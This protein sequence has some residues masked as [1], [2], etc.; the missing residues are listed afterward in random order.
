MAN[1]T[2]CIEDV[3]IDIRDIDELS[4]EDD[5]A[6]KRTKDIHTSEY[7]T[8]RYN[9]KVGN[10]PERILNSDFFQGKNINTSGPRKVDK[11]HKK[12]NAAA[13]SY[14]IDPSTYKPTFKISKLGNSNGMTTAPND[15]IA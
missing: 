2:N 1:N 10:P 14:R 8:T 4:V 3:N 11:K 15:N 6:T 5:T 9:R 7:I 13:C 12:E